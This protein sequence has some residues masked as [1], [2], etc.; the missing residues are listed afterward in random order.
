[1]SS[2]RGFSSQCWWDEFHHINKKGFKMHFRYLVFCFKSWYCKQNNQYCMLLLLPLQ[3]VHGTNYGY[4]I[5]IE[6]KSKSVCA[7]NNFLNCSCYK[8]LKWIFP[9][10]YCSSLFPS[11]QMEVVVMIWKVGNVQSFNFWNL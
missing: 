8:E 1:M 9:F 2:Y 7:Q 5:K 10:Q 11:L 6:V 3:L 4:N